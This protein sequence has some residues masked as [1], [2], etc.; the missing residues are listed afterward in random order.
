MC[1]LRSARGG[2]LNSRKFF[3]RRRN[4]VSRAWPL[5]EVGRAKRWMC[6]RELEAAYAQVQS[7][8][9]SRTS[10]PS[11]NVDPNLERTP[12]VGS[13]VA[14]TD[15]L[16]AFGEIAAAG[17]GFEEWVEPRRFPAARRDERPIEKS[18]LPVTQRR[19][20]GTVDQ[21]PA[22]SRT[23]WPAAVSH[24]LVGAARG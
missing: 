16:N 24:S 3:S 14:G 1:P 13:S 19:A 9:R 17:K 15:R 5:P 7:L 12:A 20:V 21:S 18:V 10:E 22:A 23:A 2:W 4:L 6:A 8:R 11:G